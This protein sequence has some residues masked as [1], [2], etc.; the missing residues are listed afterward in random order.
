MPQNYRLKWLIWYILYYPFFLWSKNVMRGKTWN[1][2]AMY[3]IGKRDE[4]YL[5]EDRTIFMGVYIVFQNER[6]EMSAKLWNPFWV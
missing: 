1:R 5:R 4:C 3:L 6:W 2:N